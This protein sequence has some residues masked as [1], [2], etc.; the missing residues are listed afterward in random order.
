MWTGFPPDLSNLKL[1]GCIAYAHT[2]QGK[3]ENRAKKCIFLGYCQGVK[4]YRLWDLEKG[5]EKLFISSDVM[6]N[7]AQIGREEKI[8]EAEIMSTEEIGFEVELDC[9]ISK[10]W[11]CSNFVDTDEE[12]TIVFEQG[13]S[14]GTA[15]E[16]LGDQSAVINS[17]GGT[18][19]IQAFLF[20]HIS[21]QGT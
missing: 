9:N 3:L 13:E 6:F 1:F 4:G 14:S 5:K 15:Q 12:E 16:D 21:W 17:I 8:K 2:S 18:K 20:K 11:E 19:L 7:E 10:S